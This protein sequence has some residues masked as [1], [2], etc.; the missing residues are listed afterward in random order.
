MHSI[1]PSR[2]QILQFGKYA[3]QNLTKP[4]NPLG[5]K[6]K[7]EYSSYLRSFKEKSR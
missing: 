6:P 1:T 2:K 4:Y 3:S 7:N 5:T